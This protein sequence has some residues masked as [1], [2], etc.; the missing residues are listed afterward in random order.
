MSAR[1]IVLPIQGMTCA[2][3]ANHV[4]RALK[5][6]PGVAEAQV[7]LATEKA[8]V[9]FENGAVPL[10]DLIQAVRDAGYDVATETITL[11]IGG[12]TCASCA[13]HVARAL[14]KVPGVLEANVNLATEKATVTYVPGLATMA[15]FK[16]AVAV[17][18]GHV[19][20]R[21]PVQSGTD[22]PGRTGPVGRP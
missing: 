13:N 19:A 10:Q 16:K 17:L 1:K 18:L 20:Q 12:M 14:K 15:D 6:V 9:T 21:H 2:S 7:N 8:T 22:P 11:P 5:K 4:A 3:C